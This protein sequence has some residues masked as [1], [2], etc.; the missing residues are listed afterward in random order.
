[1]THPSRPSHC[2][3]QPAVQTTPWRPRAVARLRHG[4][5][6]GLTVLLA[7]WGSLALAASLTLD[8]AHGTR[9]LDGA[10]LARHPEAQ[11]LEVP[12]DVSYQR[13]MR[14]RAVPLAVVL[15][16]LG[17]G[18]NDTLEA[19]ATDGFIAQLPGDLVLVQKPGQPKPWLAIETESAPWPALPGKA[20][21]AGP[22][23]IVWPQSVGVRSE[24][25]PFAVVR[26][27]VRAAPDKRWPQIAVSAQVPAGDRLRRGQSLFVV[28]CMVCHRMNGGGDAQVGPDLNLPMNPTEYFQPHAL[29][30]LVRNPSSVRN[31]PTQLMPGFGPAQISDAELD[32]LL[33]YL[34]HMAQQRKAAPQ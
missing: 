12:G 22:F 1:M 11:D 6:A 28:Q 21:S 33:A 16:E 19:V 14:Y 30:Q 15:R 5:R 31:W 25:W 32:D 23:Y 2:A 10:A 8:G 20:A 27:N 17:L 29:R 4:V 9:Q 24:Q 26:L 34:A 7:G 3:A 13:H 18:S